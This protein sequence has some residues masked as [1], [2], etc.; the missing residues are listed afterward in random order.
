MS[1]IRA[2]GNILTATITV[3]GDITAAAVPMSSPKSLLPRLTV[4]KSS[5]E[6][7][8][9]AARRRL[10]RSFVIRRRSQMTKENVKHAPDTNAAA[11]DNSTAVAPETDAITAEV[12][13]EHAD[14]FDDE[15]EEFRRL[16]RDLPGVKGASAGGIV[17][18]GV[19]KV[20]GRNEFFRTHP[21][22]EFSPVVPIVD[23]EVGMDRHFFAVA[24]N[25]VEALASI[26]ITVAEH[27]C[28]FTI[29]S[30]GAYRMV[31]VRG[32]NADG[33]QNE[34][35]R[36]KEIALV[37]ARKKWVRLY[38]DME[39]KCYQVFPAPPGRFTDPQWP[40]LKPSRVFRLA[41]RDKG[42]LIDSTEH[43]LFL[44]WSARDTD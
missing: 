22:P 43:P 1:S 7:E 6:T 34:W 44:K 39:N 36:T 13:Q 3:S 24:P 25:M 38:P 40:D 19:T 42:R 27:H 5:L 12:A 31:P 29:T 17:A 10:P 20:P 28:Y 41:F 32:P 30:R 8:R 33:D 23:H 14:Q 21:V 9:A 4:P 35:S 16:R 37:D 26:G 15:E 2:A 18:I 11:T